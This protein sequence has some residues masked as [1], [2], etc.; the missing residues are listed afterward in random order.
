VTSLLERLARA[1]RSAL[2]QVDELRMR[3]AE[4]EEQVR[5]LSITRETLALLTDHDGED[6]K[7]RSGIAPHDSEDAASPLPALRGLREQTE[8]RAAPTAPCS[9]TAP[10]PA[11]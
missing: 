7:E 6:G 1:E 5:R 4:A 2:R 3:L 11:R 10:W 8:C 9:S